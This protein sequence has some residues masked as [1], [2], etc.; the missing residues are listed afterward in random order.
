MK[1]ENSKYIDTS[2]WVDK[3]RPVKLDQIIYQDEIKKVLKDTLVSGELPNLLFYGPP[4]TGKTSTI[5]AFGL[6]LFGPRVINE[7]IMELNASDERGI[8]TVRDKIISFAKETISTPDPNYP[9][10]PFKII[11][12]DE[13]D[14]ITLDAQSALRKIIETS[15]RITRFCFTCNYI[16]KIIEPIVSRC[17]KFRFKPISEKALI[18]RL[19]LIAHK[20]KINI[21]DDYFSKIVNTSEGDA[22]RAIMTLQ[23][24]K[25]IINKGNT[26]LPEVNKGNTLLPEVNKGNTLLPEVNKGNTLNIDDLLGITSNNILENIWNKII[27]N[28]IEEILL[29]TRMIKNKCINI[30]DLLNYTHYKILNS[31][32][33]DSEKSKLLIIVTNTETTLIEGGD[34]FLNILYLLSQINF[35]YKK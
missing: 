19:K 35:I 22:R 8:D 15:S 7:R 32:I 4:G 24:I 25:Y 23:N 10:P 17:I 18:K 26:L 2:P 13:A 16:E 14:A 20:E 21:N 6:E 27:N 9:S 5:L 30:N 1:K 31:K 33:K 28:N 11:I 12:L 29:L 3:Y 34:E